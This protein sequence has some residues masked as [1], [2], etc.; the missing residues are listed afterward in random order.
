[1]ANLRAVGKDEK[2]PVDSSMSVTEAASKGTDRQL[3][4]AMRDRV[5]EAVEDKNTAARDLAALTKRL[6]EIANDIKALDARESEEGTGAVDSPDEDFDAA[7][8]L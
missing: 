8:A 4:V 7:K 2:P 3:L 5:A 6:R 1:M